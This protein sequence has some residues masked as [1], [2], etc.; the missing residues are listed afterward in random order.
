MINVTR[1]PGSTDN[2]HSDGHTLKNSLHQIRIEQY[3]RCP[4][5]VIFGFASRVIG[6]T[7]HAGKGCNIETQL[8]SK[9]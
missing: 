9:T 4:Q 2:Q 6:I 5:I 1:V 3:L 7:P 8:L